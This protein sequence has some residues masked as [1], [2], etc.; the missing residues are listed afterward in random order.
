MECSEISLDIALRIFD[1]DFAR[2]GR[3]ICAWLDNEWVTV[4]DAEGESLQ[5]WKWAEFVRAAAYEE[6]PLADMVI[7]LT[8]RGCREGPGSY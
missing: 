8:D 4:R 5:P 6:P 7:D 1:G 2:M 3:C